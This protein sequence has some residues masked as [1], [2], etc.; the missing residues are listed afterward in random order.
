MKKKLAPLTLHR[1]TL[2]VLTLDA[3]KVAQGGITPSAG[4]CTRTEVITCFDC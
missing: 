1:E 3:A 4:Q 2:R